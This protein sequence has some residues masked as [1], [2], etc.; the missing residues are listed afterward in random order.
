MC[1]QHNAD[2]TSLINVTDQLPEHLTD[3]AKCRLRATWRLEVEEGMARL[4]Q[5]ARMCEDACPAGAASILEG[6]EEMF[7]LDRLG[8]SAIL[9]K[10]LA[11]TSD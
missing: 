11:S 1:R 2:S 10:C 3:T 5:L 4:R 9:R 8:L 6:L 7:T